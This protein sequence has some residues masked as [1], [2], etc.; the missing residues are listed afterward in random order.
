MRKA[1]YRD[2]TGAVIKLTQDSRK[3]K[4]LE[5]PGESNNSP[6]DRIESGTPEEAQEA[7]DTAMY[8]HFYNKEGSQYQV[9]LRNAIGYGNS[10]TAKFMFEG[11][12]VTKH[13]YA[14]YVV[15]ISENTLGNL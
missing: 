1:G 2:V 5:D 3:A 9:V 15:T 10:A 12:D 13:D 6:F 11:R 7:E 8:W 14:D 4:E